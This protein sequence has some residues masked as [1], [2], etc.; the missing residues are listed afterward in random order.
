MNKRVSRRIAAAFPAGLMAL[1]CLAAQPQLARKQ[2]AASRRDE[3]YPGVTVRYDS[4]RDDTGQRLRL[5]HTYPSGGG[6]FRTIFVVGWLSC[7]SIETPPGMNDPFQLVMQS[8][9]TLPGFATE[10]ME[11]PGVGDSE[12]DCSATD[13]NSELAAYRKAFR[14]LSSLPF[15]DPQ[16]IYLFGI[17]NGGGFAPLVSQGAPVKG[18][19]V[20]G[21][22]IKTWFEHMVEIERRRLVLSNVAA[23]QVNARMKLVERLYSAYLLDRTPPARV[24]EQHPELRAVWEGDPE[25]QYERPVTYYQQLQDLNLM[26]AWSQVSAPTLVLHGQFD[27]IMSPEDPQITAALVNRNAPGA[28]QFV[29][30]PQTGHVFEHVESLPAAYSGARLPFDPRIAQRIRDWFERHRD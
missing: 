1:A 3:S 24:F 5:I 8:L 19:V 10:R 9:A 20:D 26:A 2:P 23:D 13:F 17:S 12:G 25:H 28:A 7:D 4:I 27:W 29:E 16:R 30:L 22:W 18:Y 21:G 14:N 6:K 15:V 11:K